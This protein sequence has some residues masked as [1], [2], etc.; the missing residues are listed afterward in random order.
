MNEENY[1]KRN[2]FMDD[3]APGYE[4]PCQVSGCEGEVVVDDMGFTLCH[5]HSMLPEFDRAI[6]RAAAK[7]EWKDPQI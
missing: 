2:P 1:G 6:R 7:E 4:D 3:P 5:E